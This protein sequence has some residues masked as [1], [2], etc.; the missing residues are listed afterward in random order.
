MS[1]VFET[2][3]EYGSRLLHAHPANRCTMVVTATVFRHLYEL[4]EKMLAFCLQFNLK[5]LVE[6]LSN[7]SWC[8]KIAYLTDVFHELNFFHRGMQGR[9]KTSRRRIR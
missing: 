5:D 7:N 6:V 9:K 1:S 3:W 4:R 2:L 8:S